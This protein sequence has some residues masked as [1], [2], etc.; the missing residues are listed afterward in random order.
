MLNF[1]NG[2]TEFPL[3]NFAAH[4]WGARSEKEK[5]KLTNGLWQWHCRKWGGS[6]EIYERV[7]KKVIMSIIFLQYFHNKSHMI[8][9][10]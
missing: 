2:N 7:K 5:K 10:Y 4:A 1:G 3:P 6:Y 9:Y 8:N